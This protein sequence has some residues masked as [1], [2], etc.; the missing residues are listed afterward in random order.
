MAGKRKGWNVACALPHWAGRA[1]LARE[2]EKPRSRE[3]EKP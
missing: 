3:A 2:A 1:K